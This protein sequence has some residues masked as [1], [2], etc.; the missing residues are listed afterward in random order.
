LSPPK[1]R[2]ATLLGM[3]L[4]RRQFVQL[5]IVVAGA[6]LTG[7]AGALVSACSSSSDDTG[8]ATASGKDA[9][10]DASS[11]KADASTTDAAK[12][13]APAELKCRE[14]ITQNHGHAITVPV[15]D[16]DST[17][18]K[19]YSIKGTSAHS[20]SIVLEAQDFADL[21]AGLSVKKTSDMNGETHDHDVTILCVAL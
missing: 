16:L 12:D 10:S 6:A 15:A 17:S 8:P 3:P 1:S 4:P 21:K 9:G 11:P 18:P 13:A 19:T 5:G 7:A 20:H 14:S 2:R